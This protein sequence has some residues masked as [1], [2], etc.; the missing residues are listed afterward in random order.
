MRALNT[1][2]SDNNEL[3]IEDMIPKSLFANDE[4]IKE[5][6]K[7]KEIE[8]N[9]DR[10]NLFYKSSKK[11]CDFKNFRTIRTFG[12]D[13]YKGQITFEEADEYQSDLLNKIKDFIAGTKPKSDENIQ[14]IY[15]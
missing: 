9:V 4:S 12:E 6:N 10:E 2:K 3:S 14:K 8:R 5:F 13:I 1:L 11:P 15:S 7:I